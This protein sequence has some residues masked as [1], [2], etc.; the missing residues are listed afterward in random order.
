MVDRETHQ[1]A[2]EPAPQPEPVESKNLVAIH[3][4]RPT[5]PVPNETERNVQN[6][7]RRTP[8]NRARSP[9]PIGPLSHSYSYSCSYSHSPSR[10]SFPWLASVQNTCLPCP[11]DFAPTFPPLPQSPPAQP[12]F[13]PLSFLPQSRFV[14]FEYFVVQKSMFI[15]VHPRLKILSTF[16]RVGRLLSH[17]LCY[18]PRMNNEIAARQRRIEKRKRRTPSVPFLHSVAKSSSPTLCRPSLPSAFVAN[19]YPLASPAPQTLD[20]PSFHPRFSEIQ[21]RFGEMQ[22]RFA[23]KSI[24]PILAKSREF[25]AI[26]GNSRLVVNFAG[27]H[28]LRLLPTPL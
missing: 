17:P 22:A 27:A 18:F 25:S 11:H 2:V 1:G 7:V 12:I 13:L 24:S 23:E 15:R 6:V 10:S 5:M 16:F 26:L 3:L 9:A 19:S 28:T 20:L 4:R 14:S 21:A 8:R